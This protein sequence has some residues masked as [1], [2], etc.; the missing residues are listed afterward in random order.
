MVIFIVLNQLI[1]RDKR[2]H[3]SDVSLRLLTI[4]DSMSDRTFVT[5]RSTD[6]TM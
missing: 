5:I 3:P 2:K 4:Q 1:K 6:N